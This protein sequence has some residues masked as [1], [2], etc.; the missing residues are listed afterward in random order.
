MILRF[1]NIVKPVITVTVTSFVSHFVFLRR[2]YFL[3]FD[4]LFIFAAKY[5]LYSC[6]TY[7][8]SL[9]KTTVKRNKSSSRLRLADTH[10]LSVLKVS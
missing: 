1:Y 6:S 4:A 2:L 10:N 3:L 5:V 9:L 8:C 7:F